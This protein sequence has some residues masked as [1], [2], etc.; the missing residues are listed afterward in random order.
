MPKNYQNDIINRNT[1]HQ[2]NGNAMQSYAM[3]NFLIYYTSSAEKLHININMFF[4]SQK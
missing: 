3:E 2:V 4:N 1:A